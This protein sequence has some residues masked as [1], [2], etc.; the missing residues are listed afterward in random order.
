MSL[1]LGQQTIVASGVVRPG[2]ASHPPIIRPAD[3]YYGLPGPAGPWTLDQTISLALAKADDWGLVPWEFLGLLKAEGLNVK[4]SRP[5]AQ[6][7]WRAY[8]EPPYPTFDVSFGLGQASARYCQEYG[9]W[10]KAHGIAFESTAADAYPGDAVIASIRDAYFDPYHACDVAAVGYKYWR[11]NPEVPFLQAACA[12]NGPSF[13]RTPELNPNYTHYR[14]SGEWARAQ[15]GL[16]GSGPGSIPPGT[17]PTGGDRIF[18]ADVPDIIIRQRNNWTCSVRS[19]YAGCYLAAEAGWIAPVT[20]GDEGPR[21]VYDWLVPRYANQEWG[22]L[23]H[24]GAG[25]VEALR[26]R[27]INASSQYPASLRNVQ[28]KAGTRP[29]WIGGRGWN[30]WSYV[31]GVQS[32]GTLILDNPSPGWGGIDNLLRDS[33]SRIGDENGMMS[34]VWIDH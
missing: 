30:H 18:G 6:S 11:Y 28:E 32:D 10:C 12:Y 29:V 16:M 2:G 1:K 27:Q 15:I 22:L 21:D 3:P 4:A 26:S 9:A 20:Y 19:T 34:M 24:T 14:E 33:F 5:A 7:D 17:I 25:I 23:L 8:W 13:Y 31:L